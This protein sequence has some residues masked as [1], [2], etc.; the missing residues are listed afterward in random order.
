MSLTKPDIDRA[1]KAVREHGLIVSRVILKPEE[2]EIV[3][4]TGEAKKSGP[5][6]VEL[7]TYD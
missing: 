1:L 6:P 4:E 2:G 5:A 3:I 7:T